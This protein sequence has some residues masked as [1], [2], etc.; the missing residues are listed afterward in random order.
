MRILV[1]DEL[2]EANAYC[3]NCC[4]E[5]FH[6]DDKDE[7]HVDNSKITEALLEQIDRA[8]RTCPRQALELVED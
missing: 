1:D 7:L 6:V 2:C 8:I 5:V 4:P 3:M